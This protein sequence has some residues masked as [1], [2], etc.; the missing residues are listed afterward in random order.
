[1]NGLAPGGVLNKQR[2]DFRFNDTMPWEAME[3][4]LDY[5]SIEKKVVFLD[6]IVVNRRQSDRPE[7]LTNKLDHFEPMR[8]GMFF[9][10]RK[11]RLVDQRAASDE[12]F[13]VLDE[14]IIGCI[15]S[16]LYADRYQDAAILA[17]YI[18]FRQSRGHAT[19]R[20]GSFA[21]FFKVGGIQAASYFVTINRL[22]GR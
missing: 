22:I 11:Q 3:F 16:L 13:A 1:M 19:Y 7:R 9:A 6:E 18:N 20:L 8:M 10:G 15:R 21:W 2:L 5:L 14:R 17:S 12:R 4:F